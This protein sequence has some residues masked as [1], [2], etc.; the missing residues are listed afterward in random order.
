[1]IDLEK[2]AAV[3]VG[4]LLAMA[5]GSI[6][7]RVGELQAEPTCPEP[8]P[9]VCMVRATHPATDGGEMLTVHCPEVTP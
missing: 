1:M 3:V 8:I 6:S 5:L 2:L 4:L 7:Y 9:V